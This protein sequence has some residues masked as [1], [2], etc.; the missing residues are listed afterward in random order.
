MSHPD[1]LNPLLDFSGLPRFDAIRPEHVQPAVDQ[2]IAEASAVV[3]ALQQP[4]TDVT[5]DNFVVPLETATEHLGRAWGIVNHL[6]SVMDTPELRAAYNE[7]QPKVT[8]F[9]TALSQNLALFDK[10]K[11]LKADA[12]FSA[13]TPQRRKIVDNALRDFQLGGADLSDEKKVRFAAVAERQAEL[14]TRFSENVLDATND[15]EL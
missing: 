13:L 15:Y 10:Y 9:W 5:W 8:E 7:N 14:S 12:G 4:S 6:N 11:A 1:N 2:L 3:D